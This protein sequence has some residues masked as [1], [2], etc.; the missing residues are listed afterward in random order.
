[1][2]LSLL[3]YMNRFLDTVG[4]LHAVERLQALRL[5]RRLLQ[6]RSWDSW[7]GY[8]R[9]GREAVT[10]GEALRLV[11]R[12]LQVRSSGSWGGNCI[13]GPEAREVATAGEVRRLMRRLLLV[14]PWGSSSGYFWC[15]CPWV[16]V[17]PW[18]QLFLNTC[19]SLLWGPMLHC[20]A[21]TETPQTCNL[22]HP[23]LYSSIRRYKW[24]HEFKSQFPSIVHLS[25][26]RLFDRLSHSSNTNRFYFYPHSLS[27]FF[28]HSIY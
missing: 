9:W 25:I 26:A 15:C 17:C 6:V 13:W 20:S 11:R 2:S 21:Y 3:S 22:H 4:G 5:V 27:I 24:P 14:R 8:C 7:G 18:V 16:P 28:F 19:T 12:L 1:M 23:P 10:A